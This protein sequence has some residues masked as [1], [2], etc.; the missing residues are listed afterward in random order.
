MLKVMTS[1]RAEI[2]KERAARFV[3]DVLGDEERAAAIEE[4]PLQEWAERRN[5]RVENPFAGNMK[6][7][8]RPMPTKLELER[9]VAELEDELEGYEDRE[10]Q[11]LELLGVDG[12]D[13]GSA[14]DEDED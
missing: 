8:F 9:R 2:A 5:I 1:G 12:E 4:E 6:R 3:R 13:D 11:M 7:G 10:N 14:E